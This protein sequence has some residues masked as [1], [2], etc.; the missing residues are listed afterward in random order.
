MLYNGL[1]KLPRDFLYLQPLSFSKIAPRPKASTPTLSFQVPTSQRMS[2]PA[3]NPP[4][5]RDSSTHC[6][7]STAFSL[8]KVGS[9]LGK[10]KTLW[11]KSITERKLVKAPGN[12]LFSVENRSHFQSWL[13]SHPWKFSPSLDPR[14]KRIEGEKN[15]E[16]SKSIFCNS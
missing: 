14:K 11:E 16:N 8:K 9:S 2:K 6:T 4:F 12:R 13:R 5:Q 1:I 15:S 10:A 3:R 7:R